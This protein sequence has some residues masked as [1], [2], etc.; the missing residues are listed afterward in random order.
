MVTK[1]CDQKIRDLF[2]AR[3]SEQ[4][5]V[6]NAILGAETQGYPVCMLNIM[7]HAVLEHIAGKQ[8]YKNDPINV[9]RAAIENAGANMVDQWIPENPLTIGAHGYEGVEAS[10][11]TGSDEITIDGFPIKEPEDVLD[12]LEQVVFPEIEQAIANFD[13]ECRIREIGRREYEQQME[14]GSNILKTGYDYIHFPILR[15]FTYGYIN[16]FCAYAMAPEM[17]QKDF[18]LQ[19]KL[20]A[21][22]NRA[23]I[24][25]IERYHL[26]KLF[27]LDHDMTDSRGTLVDIRSL[28]KIWFPALY[29]ALEPV[30]NTDVTLIWHCDGA[31]TPMVDPLI[32]IGIQ[33]FQGFQYEDG[34]DYPAICKKKA[35]NGKELFVIGG[36][37]VTKTLPFG[38]PEDVAKEMKWLVENHGNTRFALGCSSSVAP[39]VPWENIQALIEGFHYYRCHRS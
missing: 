2:D 13:E 15:Y 36:V 23:A 17:M 21:L 5:Q 24:K 20:N 29:R 31:I 19:S 7:E 35:K 10:A 12:H 6:S 9:Y 8:G 38:K 37:S 1:V 34:V 30:L 16:Y 33:G 26:P 14:I 18:E 28:E 32:E 22:N 25:A 11:T 4:S 3:Q 27:R 39:G